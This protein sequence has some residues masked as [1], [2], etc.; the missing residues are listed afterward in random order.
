[1]PSG[2][3]SCPVGESVAGYGGVDAA[4]VQQQT[5]LIDA[6]SGAPQNSRK[7]DPITGDYV[8]DT[9]G[10]VQGMSGVQQLV[11]MRAGTLLNSSAI[12]GLGLPGP[13]GVVGSTITQR[14]EDEL[15]LSVK[16]LTD[17]G[18]IQ[19]IGVSVVRD[20]KSHVVFRSFQWKDL[21]TGNEQ[22]TAF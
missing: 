20:P 16:D 9:F 5:I 12:P 21:T 14:M 6:N 18:V 1:M 8:R 11:L 4:P 15:R 2:L 10:R 19:I 7:V 3:G 17:A 22:E 13:S